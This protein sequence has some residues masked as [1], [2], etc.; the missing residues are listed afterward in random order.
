MS[1]SKKNKG[2]HQDG[3]QLTGGVIFYKS[4]VKSFNCEF[5]ENKGED[6]LNIIHSQ[7]ELSDVLIFTTASD[8]F[9]ADF[10]TGVISGGE[11][12][13]IGYLGGGDEN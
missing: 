13:D 11:Y 1:F 9:D 12:K 3:W 2:I 6:A 7:F 4:D 5:R 10:S 8:A